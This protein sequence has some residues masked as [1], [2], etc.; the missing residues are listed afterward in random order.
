MIIWKNELGLLQLQIISE[1][2]FLQFSQIMKSKIVTEHEIQCNM[3]YIYPVAQ[4]T[5][6]THC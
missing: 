4:L 1:C 5:T 2:Y 3:Q 6:E